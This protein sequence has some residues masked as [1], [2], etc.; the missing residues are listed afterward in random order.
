DPALSDTLSAADLFA[1]VAR[2]QQQLAAEQAQFKHMIEQRDHSIKQRDQ[3]IGLLEEQLRLK[4]IQKFTAS[5]EKFVLQFHLF[6]EAELEVAIDALRDQLPAEVE[7]EMPRA[8]SKRRQRGFSALLQRERIELTLSDA[9]K[10]G[11]SK[12]F[13]TKV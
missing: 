8:S 10:A 1:L 12:S 4:Q 2:L 9:E 5:S 13:F 11:A 7:E 3:Y 6:D